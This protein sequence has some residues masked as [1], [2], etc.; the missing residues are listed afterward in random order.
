MLHA[1]HAALDEDG[2]LGGEGPR[3][4]AQAPGGGEARAGDGSA[5]TPPAL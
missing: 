3:D 2:H 1:V 5:L 4:A